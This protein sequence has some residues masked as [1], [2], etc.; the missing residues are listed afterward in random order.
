M[1]AGA[2]GLLPPT[3]VTEVRRRPSK[4]LGRPMLATR[5]VAKRPDWSIHLMCFSF[6]L[7]GTLAQS[8][9]QG[10]R[11]LPRAR[12]ANAPKTLFRLI[13]GFKLTERLLRSRRIGALT[14]HA[15]LAYYQ[16]A[17]LWCDNLG[18]SL[19][20]L[21]SSAPGHIGVPERQCAVPL[22]DRSPSWRFGSTAPRRHPRPWQHPCGWRWRDGQTRRQLHGRRRRQAKVSC[23]RMLRSFLRRYNLGLRRH[24][25]T[26][27]SRVSLVWGS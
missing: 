25:R 16:S 2:H 5:S 12:P 1:S 10:T 9:I 22:P 8:A 21:R 11:K 14:R 3:L 26:A 27:C 20:C 18:R 13:P 19:C 6:F 24:H 23:R 17:L 7:F 4:L 15:E